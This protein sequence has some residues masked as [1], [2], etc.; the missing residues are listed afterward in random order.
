ACSADLRPLHSLPTRRSSDLDAALA[1]RRGAN[2]RSGH[3]IGEIERLVIGGD[4]A[5]DRQEAREVYALRV[6]LAGEREEHRARIVAV[7]IRSEE[8]TSE[9]QSLTKLVC[10]LL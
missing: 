5:A 9:L 7:V 6:A 4:R 10:R 3:R 8:H 2:A 1:A